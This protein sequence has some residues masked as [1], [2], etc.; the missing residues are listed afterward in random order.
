LLRM[1]GVRTFSAHLLVGLAIAVAALGCLLAL[2]A[3][4]DRPSVAARATVET[5]YGAVQNDNL[6][7]AGDN[8]A[9]AASPQFRT[10]VEAAASA[11][12]TSADGRRSVQLVRVETPSISGDTA[13]VHVVFADGQTDTVTLM[14]EGLQWKVLNSG[15]LG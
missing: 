14:R 6:D 9:R 1:P 4:S 11:A 3:C 12:Q 5:F 10:H 8:I 7:L 2:S 15:R 13:R